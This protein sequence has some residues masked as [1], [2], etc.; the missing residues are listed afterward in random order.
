[1]RVG[2][3]EGAGSRNLEALNVVDAHLVENLSD[4]GV[5]HKLRYRPHAHHVADVV[6][7]LDHGPVDGIPIDILHVGTV[8]LEIVHRQI[9]EIGKGGKPVAEIVEGKGYSHFF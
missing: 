1:M 8:Y 5:T 6:N 3:G 2:F 9:L 7:R 4:L